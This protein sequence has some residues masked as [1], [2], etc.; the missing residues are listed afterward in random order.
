M[1]GIDFC[2]S[3]VITPLMWGEEAFLDKIQAEGEPLPW[4]VA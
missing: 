4:T 1:Y 2:V 3:F